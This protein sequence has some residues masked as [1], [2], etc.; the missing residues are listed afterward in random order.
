MLI[1][2]SLVFYQCFGKLFAVP[3]LPRRWRSGASFRCWTVSTWSRWTSCTTTPSPWTS[4]STWASGSRASTGNGGQ[5]GAL[6]LCASA[7]AAHLSNPSLPLQGHGGDA[8]LAG[9]HS[10]P[11]PAGS[12][13]RPAQPLC[14]GEQLPAAAQHPK[15]QKEPAGPSPA[16][17]SDTRKS[18]A[19]LHRCSLPFQDRFQEDP[20]HMAMI[21]SRNLK[22]EQNILAKAKSMEVRR[23]RRLRRRSVGRRDKGVTE[24]C[25]CVAG[26]RE[27]GVRHGGGEAEAGQQ[28]EGDE[29]PSPGGVHTPRRHCSHC[30][31]C[32]RRRLLTPG[33]LGVF[34]WWTWTSRTWRTCRTST[35]SGST[36]WR[37]EVRR[38]SG[39]DGIGSAASPF[40]PSFVGRERDERHDGEGAGEGEDG[41][42]PDGLRAEIQASGEPRRRRWE[43]AGR[44]GG[45]PASSFQDAVIQLSDLLTVIHALLTDLISEELPEWKQRQQIA[46]IGGPPNACVDQLQNWWEPA[47]DLLQR[48]VLLRH[49]LFLLLV[50]QVH[51]RG[52]EPPAGPPA[53]E[54]AAGVGAEVHV[55]QRPHHAEESLP[56]GA[57]SGAAQKPSLQVGSSPFRRFG[58]FFFAKR[59]V[60]IS[61]FC[62]QLP[63]GGAAAVH[64][65]PP[66][67]AAGAEDR[68]PV[69]RQTTVRPLRSGKLGETNPLER[70]G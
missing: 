34:R 57:N 12:A 50:P 51:G 66:A 4:A 3:D 56:G 48:G 42:R 22:E 20:V 39:V 54:E 35:T 17:P 61:S 26:G 53:P 21:I 11:R 14:A 18:P 25:V 15:N 68:R 16:D 7:H 2:V 27:H 46:C 43:P 65:H 64:A 19:P 45:S 31:S 38:R 44:P 58:V 47:E 63:G 23:L 69:H 6:Q 24:A 10:L 30:S 40:I 5:T 60:S 55:R 9:H 41:H 52:G 29:G 8:G 37:T 59:R 67:E 36:P 62:V 13:G 1:P 70:S 49:I 28:S 33:A 32:S